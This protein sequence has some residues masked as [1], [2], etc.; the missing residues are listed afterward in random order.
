MEIYLFF[1]VC[2]YCPSE[3]KWIF[4]FYFSEGR[5]NFN[6][7][8]VGTRYWGINFVIWLVNRW[9][10]FSYLSKTKIYG[11]SA[12]KPNLNKMKLWK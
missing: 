2:I 6:F 10:W 11:K 12:E 7:I 1:F 8:Y 9:L 3:I 5:V 4:L